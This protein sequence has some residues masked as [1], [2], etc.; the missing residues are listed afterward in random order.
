M[1]KDQVVQFAAMCL[2]ALDA[3][4]GKALSPKEISRYE[5]VPIR[6]CQKIIRQLNRAGIVKFVD[7]TS[8]QLLRPVE[9][10][11]A[12]E[13]LEALWAREVTLPEFLM[14]VGGRGMRLE[15][16]LEAIALIGAEGSDFHD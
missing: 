4:P 8:V 12:L 6:D 7:R 5:G 15:K 13:L 10:I 16:T 9:E 2:H 11:T 3:N 1:K 14:L